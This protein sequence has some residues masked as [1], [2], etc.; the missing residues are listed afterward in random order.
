VR[1]VVGRRRAVRLARVIFERAGVRDFPVR[2]I[3]QAPVRHPAE[4]FQIVRHE[5]VMERARRRNVDERRRDVVARSPFVSVQR[6]SSALLLV[7]PVFIGFLNAALG[8]AEP[9]IDQLDGEQLVD[10]ELHALLPTLLAELSDRERTQ[11][12]AISTSRNS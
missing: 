1:D 7:P 4:I 9:F 8:A 2:E 5:S 11:G 12:H 6:E 3:R 10:R